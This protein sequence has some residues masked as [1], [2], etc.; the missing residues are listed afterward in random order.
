MKVLYVYG[1][2]RP[3]ESEPVPIPGYIYDLGWFPG[4]TLLSP[5]KTSSVFY[6]ERIEVTEERLSRLDDYEGYYPDNPE[7][8]LYLRV[9]YLDGE[10]YV[11]A[12][13]SRLDSLVPIEG[14]D[15]IKY[16]EALADV[17]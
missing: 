3:N 13:Q 6:A 8:S 17:D 7:G 12:D 11:Y 1:T 2:L 4:V 14:G 15:W 9:P 16:R 5:D 10:I